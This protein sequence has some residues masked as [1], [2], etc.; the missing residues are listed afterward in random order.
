MNQPDLV[1]LRFPEKETDEVTEILTG[2]QQMANQTTSPIL[3]VCLEDAIEEIAH[4]TSHES[5]EENQ[6]KTEAA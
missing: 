5:L 3:R 6:A 4:L 1:L 2:L